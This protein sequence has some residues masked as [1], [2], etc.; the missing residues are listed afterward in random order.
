MEKREE[1]VFI[2]LDRDEL[3]LGALECIWVISGF[4]FYG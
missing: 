3:K 2:Y 1:K 4:I